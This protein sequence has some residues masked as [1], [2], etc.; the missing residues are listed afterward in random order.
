[1]KARFYVIIVINLGILVFLVYHEK[2]LNGVDYFIMPN[3]AELCKV[4]PTGLSK[5]YIKNK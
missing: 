4:K 2:F 3:S 1:M 5:I